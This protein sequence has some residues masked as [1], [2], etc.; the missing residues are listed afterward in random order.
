[1][2]KWD[3][4]GGVY[5]VGVGVNDIAEAMTFWTAV[6]Y[7]PG[8]TGSLSAEEAHALYGVGS[9]LKSLQLLHQQANAGL[10]RLMQ[11]E[12]PTGSGLNMAPLKTHGNRWSVHKTDDL[13]NAFVHGEVY[14]RQGNPIYIRAFEFNFNLGKKLDDKRP[15]QEVLS[16]NSDL[17][18][19]QPEAQ[20]IV[21]T[22]INFNVSKYGTINPH[23]LLRASEGC[24]MA[25]VVQGDD[26]AVFDF[27][28]EVIGFKRGHEVEIAYRPGYMPSDMLALEPNE[29]FAEVDFNDPQAGDAPEE[30]L[31]GRL[32]CF[33][34]RSTQKLDDRLAQAQP[35]HLGYSL[36]TFRCADI[37]R[38]H[39]RVA[40]SSATDVTPIMA[41][42]FGNPAFSFTAP[43]GFKWLALPASNA[44]H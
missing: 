10:V 18:L 36:Y 32:R 5:E 11:W 31:P 38:M 41:D 35:G 22:R 2:K 1:M 8:A 9:G 21:M 30:H 23:S 25:L 44:S 27:Y 13:L 17:L 14:R 19:F 4:I 29:S 16:A 6:G 40:S 37:T 24:H 28:E 39:S 3:L 12:S 26:L 20:Y 15:F 34:L 42:E 7:R 43:D 33:V